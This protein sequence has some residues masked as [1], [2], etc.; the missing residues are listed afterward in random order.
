MVFSSTAAVY[1]DPTDYRSPET[2]PSRPTNP[3]GAT[4]LAVDMA[5]TSET[6]ST[7]WPGSRLRYFNVAGASCRRTASGTRPRRT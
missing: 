6:R 4:K 7:A 2:A 3:Y 1:G 5:L